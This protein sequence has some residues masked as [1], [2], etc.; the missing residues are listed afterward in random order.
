MTLHEHQICPSFCIMNYKVIASGEGFYQRL[1]VEINYFSLHFVSAIF[2]M[3]SL[4]TSWNCIHLHS[5][6]HASGHFR[7]AISQGLN[8]QKC[9]AKCLLKI[10]KKR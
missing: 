4:R 5:C 10:L 3:A 6:N 8:P 2:E 7:D 1:R 9:W